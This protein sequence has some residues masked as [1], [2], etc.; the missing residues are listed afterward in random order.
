MTGRRDRGMTFLEIMIVIVILAVLLAVVLPNMA[1]P[2]EKAAL[3]GASRQLASAGIL[4]RQLAISY[5]EETT[6][7]LRP[8]TGEWQLELSP[9]ADEKRARRKKEKAV[10]TEEE[11]RRTLPARIRFNSIK[12]NNQEESLEGEV[13]LTFYPGGSCSGMTL[14]LASERGRSITVD[15][16]R[17]TG[18]PDVYLGAPKS[19]AQRLKEQGFDPAAYGLVDDSPLDSAAG[20]EP[21]EGFYR[22]AGQSSDERVAAYKDAIDRM[23]ER[24][25]TRYESNKAGGP[26]A[27]YSEAAKWG[28]K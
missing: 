4:A 10:G 25:K 13:R 14:E 27:Y 23:M 17:A 24:S 9:E 5:Q 28:S 22:V 8:K 15:F 3:R 20:S 7:M 26:G 21:G 11:Q 12:T 6:L 19:L 1:G 16:E 18:R 2:R